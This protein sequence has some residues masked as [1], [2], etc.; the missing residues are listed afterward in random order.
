M[1]LLKIS[2]YHLRKTKFMVFLVWNG[3]GKSVFLKLICGFY[4]PDSGEI[5]IDGI[6]YNLCNDFPKD[7]RALIEKP[8]F[9]PELTGY[10][11]LK[12]LADIQRK[13][14]DKQIREALDIVNLTEDM[15]KK[16]HKY[17][18]GMKQKLGI[19][20]VI[21]ENPK[22]MILDEPFRNRRRNRE[23]INYVF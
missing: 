17:S 10:E 11:N 12:L 5:K 6:N 14:D 21:M 19:A 22:I 2:Q 13:I 8:S 16:Y 4:I 20:Q 15:D 23:E 18:L 9:F 7:L 3:T 1:K